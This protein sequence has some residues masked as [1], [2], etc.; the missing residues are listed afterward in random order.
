MVGREIDQ[1]R[2]VMELVVPVVV[3]ILKKPRVPT[4]WSVISKSWMRWF[5]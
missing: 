4:G 3:E 5:Q 1:L 2:Q